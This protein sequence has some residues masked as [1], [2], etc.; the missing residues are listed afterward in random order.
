MGKLAA[1]ILPLAT[2]LGVLVAV[3]QPLGS[4][5][6]LLVVGVLAAAGIVLTCCGYAA[7]RTRRR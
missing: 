1:T 3:T 5:S 6:V 7:A 4:D 2:L